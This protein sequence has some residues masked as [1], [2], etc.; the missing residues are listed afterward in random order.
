MK[1]YV[2]LVDSK[3]NELGIADKIEVHTTKP[4]LHRA[5]TYLLT[6]EKGEFL[7]TK[8]SSKKLVWPS[9]WET[10]GSTHPFEN[11]SHE[12]CARRRIKEELGI[13]IEPKLIGKFEYKA[14]DENRG[15]EHEV[16]ALL[17]GEVFDELKPDQDE[18]EGYKFISK[19]ELEQEIKKNPTNYAPWLVLALDRI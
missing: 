18:I 17:T 7:I 19:R 6:N 4:Q 8:R 3:N 9:F 14:Q 1:S 12:E 11:E 13:D 5:V 15:W 16:C 10:S 2:I